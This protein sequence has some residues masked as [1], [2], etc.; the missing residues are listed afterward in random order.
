MQMKPDGEK[1]LREEGLWVLRATGAS[2][3]P[4]LFSI[5]LFFTFCFFPVIKVNYMFITGNEKNIEEC[6]EKN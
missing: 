5:S 6:K 4:G 3:Q 2:R 1:Y